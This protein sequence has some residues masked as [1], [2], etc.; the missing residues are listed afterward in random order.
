MTHEGAAVLQGAPPEQG[1]SVHSGACAQI[2]REGKGNVS[3]EDVNE[4]AGD[5]AIEAAARQAHSKYFFG[6]E[7]FVYFRTDVFEDTDVVKAVRVFC[8][9]GRRRGTRGRRAIWI[10]SAIPHRFVFRFHF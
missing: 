1:P 9:G 3:L 10:F 8:R 7:I 6:Q 2:Y 4:M 5:V